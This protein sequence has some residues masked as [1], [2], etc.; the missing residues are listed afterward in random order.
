M[1]TVAIDFGTSNTVISVINPQKQVP[2]SLRFPHIS[3]IFQ[4]KRQDGEI[5][6]MPVIPS[7][8]FIQ[9][10]HQWILGQQVRAKRLGLRESE[11]D[12]IFKAFKRDLVADF[13]S[14]PR[15]LEG[16]SYTPELVSERFLMEI[17][18]QLDQQ[19]IVPQKVIFTVPIEA[20]ERYLDWFREMGQKLGVDQVQIVD[21]STAAA[22]GYAVHRPGALVLVVD[23]G[24][25]PWISVW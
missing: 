22:L 14:P 9:A 3:R 15:H 4:Q 11:K 2:I 16:I 13:Q 19:N 8:V 20:F 6:E 10:G 24:G 17:W 1:T 7:L 25:E 18:Q 12:R 5:V 23:F 21:E